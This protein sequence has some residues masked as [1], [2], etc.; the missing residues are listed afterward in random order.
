MG[1]LTGGGLI[2][3]VGVLTGCSHL[4]AFINFWVAY[5][6]LQD[7]V[8]SPYLM[9]SGM[10]V[11]PLLVLFGVLAGEELAGIPGMSSLFR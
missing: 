6:L 11:H 10:E 5:R 4:V 3:V 7:Y 9:N 1:P 8:L 2:L